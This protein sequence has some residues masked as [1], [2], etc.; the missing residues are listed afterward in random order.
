MTIKYFFLNSQK[1]YFILTKIQ[2]L[3]HSSIIENSRPVCDITDIRL[4]LG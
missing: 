2:T 3:M 1:W 4:S